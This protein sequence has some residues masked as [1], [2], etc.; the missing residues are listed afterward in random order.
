MGPNIEVAGQPLPTFGTRRVITTLRLRDG[1][2]NLLAGLLREEDRRSL[3]GFPGLLHLP[4]I[5]QLF[6]ANDE[7]ISSTDIVMLLT[8]RIVRTHEL[9]QEDVNPIF[10]GTQQNMGISGPP[11][12]IAPVSSN[13]P[14]EVDSPEI[15]DVSPSGMGA[16]VSSDTSIFLGPHIDVTPAMAS[17]ISVGSGGY[18]VPIRVSGAG[19]VAT[20]SLSLE[21][22]PRVLRVSSVREGDFTRQR[23][24]EVAFAKDVDAAA[25][26]I[27]LALTKW[28][29]VTGNEASGLI[30][31]V[32]F[33]PVS[34]GVSAVTPRGLGLTSS[35][36]PLTLSFEPTTVSVR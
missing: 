2:S 26:R 15:G 3:R 11:P 6:S 25:G 32:V 35:G 18:T 5:R 4:I 16:D 31:A 7:S 29:A 8:P 17:E 13:I 22:D 23:S 10:I 1:E 33:E 28:G 9:T 12:L 30:A 20:L 34:P 21:F 19:D 27:D 24:G 36:V 14:D